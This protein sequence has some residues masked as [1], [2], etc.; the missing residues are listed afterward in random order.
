[1]SKIQKQNAKMDEEITQSECSAV[2]E[3]TERVEWSADPEEDE[4]TANR[5]RGL[6]RSKKMLC[7][8]CLAGIM[9][10]LAMVMTRFLGFPQTGMWRLD[11]GFL[12]IVLVALLSGPIWA[13]LSYGAA[14][15]IGAALF[16]GINPFITVEKV[17]IG[18]IFGLAYYRKEK[19]SVL[20]ILVSQLIVAVVCDFLMMVPIFHFSFGSPWKAALI[21][22]A[23]SAGVNFAMRC[24]LLFLMNLRLFA[25]LKKRGGNY[26]GS[27]GSI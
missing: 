8:L 21:Y 1:M 20:R 2:T 4:Q 11:P 16:T 19:M 5:R 27:I 13:G 17:Y 7:D 22:R 24:L 10:A 25:V 3:E 9:A 26:F 14:D 23:V 18:L 15:L 6:A 12:P